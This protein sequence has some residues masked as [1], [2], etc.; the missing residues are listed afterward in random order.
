[1]QIASNTVAAVVNFYKKELSSI[2]SDSELQNIIRWVLQKQLGATVTD[3]TSDP[4][5]RINESDMTP[6]EKM[7]FELKA[8]K[9]IQYVLGEAEFYGLRFMVNENVLIP[10]PET[11]ELVEMV[12]K[13]LSVRVHS[14]PLIIDIGA[15]SGCIPVTIKDKIPSARVLAL[16]ISEKALETAKLNASVN[17][18]S[19]DLLNTDIRANS[20][21]EEVLSATK[22][23]KADII[24]SN[25]PYVLEKESSSLHDRVRMYEPHL[26]LFVPDAD[27]LLFYRKIAQVAQKILNSDGKLWFECHSDHAAK[28]EEMLLEMQ[29]CNVVLH[30]DMSGSPRFTEA[31]RDL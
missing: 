26:A 15:G 16:D 3:I 7:C 14:R 11:E 17:H 28:V 4:N 21:A 20:A 2:Y 19:I 6:L 1:M 22:Q 13:D 23:Q 12:I 18:V 5:V 30:Y 8:N 9:P 10:R 27:P 25:P 24:I 29:F 31:T